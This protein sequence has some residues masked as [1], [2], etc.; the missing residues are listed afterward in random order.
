MIKR[1]QILGCLTALGGSY[2]LSGCG[3]SGSDP[4]SDS[5]AVAKATDKAATASA[6]GTTIPPAA[7]IIDNQGSVWTLKGGSVYLNGVKAGNN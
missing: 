2:I 4:G 6:N 1:R 7:K 5:T 3:G